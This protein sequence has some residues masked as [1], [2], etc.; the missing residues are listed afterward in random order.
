MAE[1]MDNLLANLDETYQSA[2]ASEGGLELPAGDYVFWVKEA[3][4]VQAKSSDKIQVKMQV[5]VVDG[6]KYN[7]MPHYSYDLRFTD[8]NGQPDMRAMGFFKLACQRLGLLPPSTMQ[9]AP[10]TVS[11]MVDRVFKGRIVVS[12]DFRN[13]RID[14]LIHENYIK[15]VEQG[16]P[17]A[18]KPSADKDW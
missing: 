6:G 5:V 12:G 2:E 8:K 1:N 15:W 18:T 11:K 10:E 9:D 13:L 3:Q 7:N 17:M 16:A 4:V 14:S